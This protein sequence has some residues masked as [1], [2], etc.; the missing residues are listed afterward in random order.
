MS[1]SSRSI[2]S[3]LILSFAAL[4]SAAAI[5]Q[6]YFIRVQLTSADERQLRTWATDIATE[7][8]YRDHWDLVGFRRSSPQAQIF[9]VV[10]KDGVLVD[11]EG[12]VPGL[13]PGFPFSKWTT[14]LI[15]CTKSPDRQG[16]GCG[17]GCAEVG[18]RWVRGK[19]S[20]LSSRSMAG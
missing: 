5:A 2:V 10:G 18:W 19:N 12:I 4:F 3:A 20:P 13:K 17:R 16:F 15:R 6:Y 9:W 8:A 1:K 14:N 7:I 11:A